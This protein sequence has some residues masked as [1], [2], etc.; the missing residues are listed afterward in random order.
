MEV[1]KKTLEQVKAMIK[2]ALDSVWVI[3]DTIK[4]IADGQPATAD[5]KS[6]IERNVSHLKLI[7]ADKDVID[8]KED[9]TALTKGVATGEAKLAEKGLWPAA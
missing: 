6:N 4:Q 5:R 9:I 1:Q 3:E 8:S 2:S 7:V